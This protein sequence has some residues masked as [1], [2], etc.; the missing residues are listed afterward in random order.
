MDQR[1]PSIS[2]GSVTSED[3]ASKDLPSRSYYSSHA[4]PDIGKAQI[5]F[6]PL[7]RNVTLTQ[8]LYCSLQP[9]KNTA[10]P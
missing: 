5:S 3:L 10:L 1:R 6:H 8:T 4:Q 7:L 2:E 9:L